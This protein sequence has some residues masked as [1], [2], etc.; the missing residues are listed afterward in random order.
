M[1]WRCV[2]CGAR[3]PETMKSCIG[4]DL[5]MGKLCGELPNGEV[6]EEPS[7]DDLI[8]ALRNVIRAYDHYI[9]NVTSTEQSSD[10]YELYQADV[11]RARKLVQP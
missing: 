7:R 3:N 5:L 10:A 1:S 9:K 2:K 6:K 8:L 11:E 4:F